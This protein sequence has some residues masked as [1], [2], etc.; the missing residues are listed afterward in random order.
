MTA[1]SSLPILTI[2]F[3]WVERTS[4][5]YFLSKFQV[6][7][8]FLLLTIVTMLYIVFRTYSSFNGKFVPFDQYLP[9]SPHPSASGNHHS[10]RLLWVF[11]LK[12]KKNTDHKETESLVLNK[13]SVTCHSR[14]QR[15]S[16]SVVKWEPCSFSSRH[17][18][19]SWP[20][21]RKRSG[22]RKIS[23]YWGDGS[24]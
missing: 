17:C 23:E 5:I 16:I 21:R 8:T 7:N 24:F 4:E 15:L 2:S 22:M 13:L 10:T 20:F 18:L 9:L 14:S 1:Y 3:L 6:Y 19:L 11:N 12:K